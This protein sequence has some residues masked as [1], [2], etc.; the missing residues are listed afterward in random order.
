MRLRG[1]V[2]PIDAVRRELD[3]A[4]VHDS[5]LM[6]DTLQTT[7]TPPPE[8]KE[9]DQNLCI[10]KGYSGAPADATARVFGCAPHS[11]Q[12]G[13]EKVDPQ[14][15]EKVHPARR[16]VV[17]RAHGWLSQ[18]RSILVRYCKKSSNYL[19]IIKL[20]CILL[21]YRRLHRVMDN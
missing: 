5:L 13:Q 17:E 1:A 20:Q 12:I 8:P 10:D 18:C 16:W 21:W 4:N 9:H 14:S 19:G 11:R 15:G 3:G 6:K 2:K 7:V